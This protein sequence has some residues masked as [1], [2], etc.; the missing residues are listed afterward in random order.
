[1]LGNSRIAEIE[2][3]QSLF[4]MSMTLSHE[5]PDDASTRSA[6]RRTVVVAGRDVRERKEGEVLDDVEAAGEVVEDAVEAAAAADRKRLVEPMVDERVEE[7][8]RALQGDADAPDV[9][10]RRQRDGGADRR[11]VVVHLRAEKRA[12]LNYRHF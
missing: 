11:Q 4:K 12:S 5:F 7:A 3:L 10:L 2:R 9:T 1:M 8:W 6:D